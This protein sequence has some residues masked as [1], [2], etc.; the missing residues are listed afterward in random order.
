MESGGTRVS[1]ERHARCKGV[2][3]VGKHFTTNKKHQHTSC[4]SHHVD[5]GL[6]N[7]FLFEHYAGFSG[8]GK[9]TSIVILKCLETWY[10]LA[11]Y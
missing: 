11:I 9:F 3:V 6:F 10:L 4:V 5:G 1:G 2:T 7:I 8:E